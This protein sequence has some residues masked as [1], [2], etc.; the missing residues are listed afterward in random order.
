M[1]LNKHAMVSEK[2]MNEEYGQSGKTRK[3]IIADYQEW[4]EEI[5]DAISVLKNHTGGSK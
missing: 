3:Q 2:E 1:H 5:N 4:E